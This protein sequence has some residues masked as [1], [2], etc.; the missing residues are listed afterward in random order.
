MSLWLNA[1]AVTGPLK[2]GDK[3]ARAQEPRRQTPKSRLWSN[4]Q[5]TTSLS[6]PSSVEVHG[7][8]ERADEQQHGGLKYKN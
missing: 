2:K 6:F 1:G 5:P 3:S 4:S 7:E 8:N